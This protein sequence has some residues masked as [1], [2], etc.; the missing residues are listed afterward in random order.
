MIIIMMI[1][2]SIFLHA[3]HTFRNVWVRGRYGGGKT[4]LAV[5]L[6]D[7]LSR[8]YG[9]KV[10]ANIP[11]HLEKSV[12][13]LAT[14]DGTSKLC[15]DGCRAR[16]SAGLPGKY[17]A[18]VIYDEAWLSLGSGTSPKQIKKY[19]AYLRKMDVVLLMPSVLQMARHSYLLWCER[20]MNL[21]AL[22]IPIWSYQWA[23]AG[24]TPKKDGGTF[25]MV[26][27]QRW[28]GVYDTHAQPEDLV[29]LFD[30]VD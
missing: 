12:S 24:S 8:S 20:K 7:S 28:F 6:A 29:S 15:D 18:V 21:G 17:H 14:C 26:R 3:V 13:N 4:L 22:G 11:V 19:L 1:G 27:P 23:V 9:Y 2:S 25:Y 5:A 30:G 16:L 10:Y